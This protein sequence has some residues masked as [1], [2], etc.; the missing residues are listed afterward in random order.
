[1]RVIDTSMI[2]RVKKT[3]WH[4][5]EGWRLVKCGQGSRAVHH[6]QHGMGRG[7]AEPMNENTA[8]C[9]KCGTAA[10]DDLQGLHRLHNWD[11]L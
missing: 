9:S 3:I 2:I 4:D 6:C 1:M 10:P 5:D 7:G 11:R 8:K